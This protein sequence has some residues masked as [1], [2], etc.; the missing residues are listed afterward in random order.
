MNN[1]RKKCR[2]MNLAEAERHYDAYH[3]SWPEVKNN[4]HAEVEQQLK[5]SR[6]LTTPFGRSRYF[7]GHM[8]DDWAMRRMLNEAL[9]YVPQ[10]HV[11]DALNRGNL[12]FM[13]KVRSSGFYVH[14]LQQGHD[15]NIW[16]VKDEEVNYVIP[17]LQESYNSVKF[18]IHGRECCFPL[19]IETG[20]NWRGMVEWK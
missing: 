13:E 14:W 15:G 19:E 20:K 5:Q 11:S 10:S 4:W 17:I 2:I 8:G 12:I 7:Y 6:L 3:S 18:N 16:L 1:A 9:S